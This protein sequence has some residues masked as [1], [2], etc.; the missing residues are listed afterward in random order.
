MA[1]LEVE[2]GRSI[3]YENY[4]GEGPPIVLVHGWGMSS[5]C[6]DLNLPA[7]LEGG[8]QVILFDQRC[9]G[10]SDKDFDDVSVESAA[11]D[12]AALV[13]AVDLDSPALLGWSFGAAVV[14]QAAA[15]MGDGI[16][17]I[18]LSGPPTPRYTQTDD[19]PHG[20]T[21]EVIEETLA[22]LR[23]TRPE[24]LFG[25]AQGVC[26]AEVGEKTVEWMWEAMMETSPRADRGLRSLAEVDH[27][28]QMPSIE[29]PA[30]VCRGTNDAIVDPAIAAVAAE[31]LPNSVLIDFA[32][33]GH[34][35]FL[36]ESK[37]FNEL[38]VSFAADPRAAL[39][40]SAAP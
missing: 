38:L 25:L 3:Y 11:K 35:P 32:D 36:E 5:R 16:S 14:V 22:A 10:R 1:Y 6:W 7:L 39:S 20:G 34:A 40:A 15:D 31:L 17:G 19:F 33:S 18:M 37:R 24:F 12:V 26:H 2:P 13:R 23:D 8:H 30:L 9:C 29:V 4:R 28:A 21:M 27:R